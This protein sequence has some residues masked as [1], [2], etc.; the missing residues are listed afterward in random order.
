M[1]M[2]SLQSY[3]AGS[4]ICFYHKGSSVSNETTYL[5][6]LVLFPKNLNN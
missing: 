5:L 4:E 3:F 6:P 1:V 2:P